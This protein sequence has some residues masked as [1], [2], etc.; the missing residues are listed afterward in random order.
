M[1]STELLAKQ[2]QQYQEQ[3]E[4]DHDMLSKKIDQLL[5]EIHVLF[6]ERN[7]NEKRFDSLEEG[8]K[9]IKEVVNEIDKRVKNL[10]EHHMKND[11]LWKSILKGLGVASIIAGLLATAW[12]LGFFSAWF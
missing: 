10:E 11:H 7:V 6:S 12:K 2:I 8:Q 5:T 1:D 4:R 3:N 9:E